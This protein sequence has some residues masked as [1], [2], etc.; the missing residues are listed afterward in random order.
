[1]RHTKKYIQEKNLPEIFDLSTDFFA[2]RKKTEFIE[3]IHFFIPP[4]SS[5]TK[6]A[7]LW[8]IEA[9]DNWLRG[10]QIDDEIKSLLDRK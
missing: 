10:N 3:G 8:D 1:M 4:N 5:K 9:L 6:K 7:I 2:Q